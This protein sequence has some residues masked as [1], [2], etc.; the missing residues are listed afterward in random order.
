MP[1][2]TP[3]DPVA[4]GL[5][6]LQADAGAT[7]AAQ[8]AD[9]QSADALASAQHQKDTTGAA[10]VSTQGKQNADLDALKALLE[11]TYRVA[12]AAPAPAPAA[13]VKP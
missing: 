8:T 1:E 3:T 5:A 10:V 4:A 9:S 2:T 7:A 12:V 11:Q 13:P 6:L